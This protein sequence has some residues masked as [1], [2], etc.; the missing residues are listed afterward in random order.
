[1]KWNKEEEDILMKLQ[2]KVGI[3]IIDD[4]EKIFPYRSSDAIRKKLEILKIPHTKH[5]YNYNI[6]YNY[7]NGL[8]SN[9]DSILE[10]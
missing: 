5:K 1:M 3:L 4:L 2:E 7:L 10:I 9:N 6:D 8:Y